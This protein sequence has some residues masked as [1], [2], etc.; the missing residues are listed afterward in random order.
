MAKQFERDPE[1]ATRC[2]QCNG[3]GWVRGTRCACQEEDD[4]ADDRRAAMG[5]VDAP[6]RPDGPDPA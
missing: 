2:E 3:T 5:L 6:E 4:D 1:T